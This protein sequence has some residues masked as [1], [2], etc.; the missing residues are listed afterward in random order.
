VVC[1]YCGGRTDIDLHL[2]HQNTVY[3]PDSDRQCPRCQIALHT[4]DLKIRGRFYIEQCQN[5]LGLFLDTGELEALLEA[6]VSNVFEVN[7]KEIDR[8][9]RDRRPD[10]YGI[11][12]I[13]CPVCTKHMNR[14]NYGHKSGVVIDQCK[15]HGIWLDGGELRHLMDW[16]K[17]GGQ[18]LHHHHKKEAEDR[19]LKAEKKKAPFKEMQN[20]IFDKNSM[21]S[22]AQSSDILDLLSQG[23]SKLFK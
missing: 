22:P 16:T 20:L 9:N 6:S 8:I 15:E 10:N 12:Y 18:L 11:V 7:R 21:N 3:H 5:C 13:K 2:I 1:I 17:A 14:L 4:L 23:L 19:A